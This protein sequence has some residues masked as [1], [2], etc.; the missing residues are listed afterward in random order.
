MRNLIKKDWL[1]TLAMSK[2]IESSPTSSSSLRRKGSCT[3][4][5]SR[6]APCCGKWCLVR[7]AGCRPISMSHATPLMLM[8]RDALDRPYHRISYRFDP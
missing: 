2:S 4:S 3:M 8:M 7:A 1:E 6:A 5:G